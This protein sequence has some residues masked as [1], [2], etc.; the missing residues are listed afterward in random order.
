MT[1]TPIAF[2][3]SEASLHYFM[4]TARSHQS[5]RPGSARP[6][7]YIFNE[8]HVV[9][10]VGMVT[11]F[12]QPLTVF[13]MGDVTKLTKTFNVGLTKGGLVSP[14]LNNEKANVLIRRV[15]H[16]LKIVDNDECPAPLKA[17]A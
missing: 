8:E 10:N 6:G 3:V 2:V 17:F 16:D 13:T 7:L 15:L 5:P 11:T 9:E 4:N 1:L 12:L 14:A